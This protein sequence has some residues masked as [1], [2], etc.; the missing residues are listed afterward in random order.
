MN[1]I[2]IIG[3]GGHGRGILEILRAA[4]SDRSDA[5]A[6]HGFL[7]DHADLAGTTVGGVSVLGGLGLVP[8]LAGRHHFLIGVGDPDP[9]REIA[10]RL[11]EMEAEFATA[12]HPSAVIYGDVTLGPGTV[13]GAGVVIAANTTLGPHCLVNLGATVGHDC[14]L[15][16]YATVGPGANLGG[17]VTMDEGSFVGLGGVVVPGKSIG[18]GSKLGPGSVL[19]E[20]LGPDR[21]A[22]GVPARVVDRRRRR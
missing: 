13:I 18:S 22:F 16:A 11:S 3:A 19:L 8:E 9:R 2:V 15:A 21:I 17:F 10:L 14:R 12:V 5:P 4:A 6:V 20:D 1:G 7:D